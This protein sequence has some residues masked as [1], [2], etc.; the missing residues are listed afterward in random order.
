F[1][2]IY[3]SFT[4]QHMAPRYAKGYLRE[5]MRVLA[6]GGVLVFNLPSEPAGHRSLRDWIIGP[7]VNLY[8]NLSAEGPV[9]EM[10]GVKRKEVERLLEENTG[11]V[12]DTMLRR[13]AGLDWISYRY[14][15]VKAA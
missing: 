2:F 11:R 14:A 9:M 8:C 4:L 12:L 5:F 10:H 3:S 7:V 15:V 13:T 1:D 6:P